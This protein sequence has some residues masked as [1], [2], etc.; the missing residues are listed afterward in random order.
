MLIINLSILVGVYTL[1]H[2]VSKRQAKQQTIT[3][4]IDV[5]TLK[6]EPKIIVTSPTELI[7]SKNLHYV[8]TAGVS[9]SMASAAYFIYPPLTF[10]NVA[11]LSYTLIPILKKTQQSWQMDKKI[12]V[13]SYTSLTSILMLGTGNYFATGI[14]T[15]VYYISE[16]LIEKSRDEETVLS[17]QVFQQ[18][19]K[20]VW[21]EQN[22][23]ERQVELSQIQVGDNIIVSTGEVIPM[24]GIIS[25]GLALV[26]QQ[27]LT[28]ESYPIEKT[29]DDQVLSSTLVLSGRITIRATRSGEQNRI[30]ALN[31]LLQ[32]RAYYK[33]QLQLKGEAWA[34]KMVLPVMASSM[35]LAP[36]IGISSAL[37]LLFSLPANTVRS[38]LSAQTRTQMDW[39]TQQGIFIKDGRVLEELPRIDTLLFDK[40][41][42]LTQTDPIV[43]AII[44]C[45]DYDTEQLLT[46]AAAAEQRLDHPIA[47]A[48]VKKAQQ[49]NLV[50]P[51]V[52]ESHYD[53]GFGISIAVD[54]DNISVGSQ[55]FIQKLCNMQ[56]LPDVIISV[57]QRSVQNTFVIIAINQKIEGVLELQTPLRAEVPEL[58]Q[59]LRQRG[60]QQLSIVSGDQAAPTEQLTNLL[61]MD[62]AYSE[63]LPQDKASLIQTLQAQGRRVCFIGDG[64]N[65]ALAMKQ[66]NASICLQSAST[67]SRDLAQIVLLNDSL[68]PLNDVFDQA[69]ELQQ[70]LGQS[71]YFWG[72]FGVLNAAA[73]PLL[74]FGAFQSSLLFSVAYSAGLWN[75]K[76]VRSKNIDCA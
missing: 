4:A 1:K 44:S 41:G 63:V 29:I 19:P 49:Q 74:G 69:S 75:A 45:G 58:I 50:L 5:N 15:A 3:P 22:G 8:K 18:I 31:Q 23:I 64:I 12:T 28:G 43:S 20:M 68:A 39:I 47:H 56:A 42:T 37:A 30:E 24:D 48:I 7:D 61:G 16:H 67:V 38:M 6:N 65:D 55:R 72:G 32:Q 34:D 73:V 11:L 21:L 17:K 54:Q 60:F 53:L 25:A 35:A 51:K 40:T 76:Q 66:A 36:L 59:R 26:D 46:F 27:A 62:D 14:H 70:N 13:H 52:Y 2:L 9:M 71:L 10:L 57:M 33:S